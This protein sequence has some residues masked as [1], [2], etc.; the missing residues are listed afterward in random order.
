MP[1]PINFSHPFVPGGHPLPLHEAL[2]GPRGTLRSAAAAALRPGGGL[3]GAG[4]DH[5]AWGE[6]WENHGKT[7]GKCGEKPQIM[8]NMWGKTMKHHETTNL[9]DHFCVMNSVGVLSYPSLFH[10]LMENEGRS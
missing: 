5:Q 1:F 2:R 3:S 9:A 8:E 6:G 10:K 4:D 7:M